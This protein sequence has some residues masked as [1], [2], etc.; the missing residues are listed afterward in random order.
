MTTAAPADLSDRCTFAIEAARAAGRSTLALFRHA[1]LDVTTKGDGTDVTAADRTAERLLRDRI[2]QRFP[3]DAIV[4]EEYEDVAGTSGW[5]WV[6]DPIDGTTSFI[7]GV[8]LFGTLLAGMRGDE[9]EIGVVVIPALD[10]FVFAERGKGAWSASGDGPVAPARVSATRDLGRATVL[11]TSTD[12]F[13]DAGR[14]EHY[15]RVAARCRHVRGWGDAYAYLLLA[16][17]RADAVVEPAI[18]IWDIAPMPAIIEEAGGRYSDWSGAAGARPGD[19]LAS[20]GAIHDEL[21][22]LLRG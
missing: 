15:R 17:G 21:L 20:N 19:V 6:I 22:E 16:T 13:D 11:V 7:H 9:T 4:G 3:D 14:S 10:E 5:R 18:S 12:Y 2:Q 8:P 1:E